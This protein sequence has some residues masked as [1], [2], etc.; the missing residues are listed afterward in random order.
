MHMA[1]KQIIMLK[2][3]AKKFFWNSEPENKELE[4]V[5]GQL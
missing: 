1:K 5:S 4:T 2:D 3:W